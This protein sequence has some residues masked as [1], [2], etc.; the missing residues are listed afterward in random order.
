M[1]PIIAAGK[2]R[3]HFINRQKETELIRNRIKNRSSTH[4]PILNV[5]GEGGIGKS[6]L[7]QSISRRATI[8]PE[9]RG[10]SNQQALVVTI[11][12]GSESTNNSS[13]NTEGGSGED[14]DG[15]GGDDDDDCNDPEGDFP[16]WELIVSLNFKD[17]IVVLTITSILTFLMLL[18]IKFTITGCNNHRSDYRKIQDQQSDGIVENVGSFRRQLVQRS[19]NLSYLEEQAT[20]YPAGQIPLE[21]HNKIEKEKEAIEVLKGRIQRWVVR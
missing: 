21:L 4:D 13:S 1:N 3:P 19:K 14:D 20:L 15:G 9:T 7:L 10:R 18:G 11:V 12:I 17:S 2:I 5:Y 8:T 16:S 6:W